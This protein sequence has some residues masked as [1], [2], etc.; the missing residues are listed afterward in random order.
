MEDVDLNQEF[1]IELMKQG[2]K[3][4]DEKLKEILRLFSE[5]TKIAEWHEIS[6]ENPAE[7]KYIS[8][9]LK[10]KIENIREK[11]GENLYVADYLDQELEM[12]IFTD[13]D[14]DEIHSGWWSHSYC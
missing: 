13:Y 3:L 14:S 5:A 10:K 7:D 12:N 6:F 8:K 9:S 1:N 11:H 4:V 2:K